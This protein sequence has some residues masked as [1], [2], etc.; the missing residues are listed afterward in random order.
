MLCPIAYTRSQF[1]YLYLVAVLGCFDL[2]T[3]CFLNWINYAKI[4]FWDASSQSIRDWF[5]FG[6][7]SGVF[8]HPGI[9]FRATSFCFLMVLIKPCLLL[10]SVAA[11]LVT[12]LCWSPDW[13]TYKSVED[14]TQPNTSGNKR[15]ADRLGIHLMPRTRKEQLR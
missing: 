15:V 7:L 3:V 8:W 4:C 13:T 1:R 14:F 12:V 5:P 10:P 9:E 11:L 2:Q 6:N